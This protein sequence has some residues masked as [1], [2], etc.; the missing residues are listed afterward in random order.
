MCI[1]I[2][3]TQ[4]NKEID[5]TRLLFHLGRIL[6]KQIFILGYSAVIHEGIHDMLYLVSA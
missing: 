6:S 3:S 5:I 1:L 4:I 2:S